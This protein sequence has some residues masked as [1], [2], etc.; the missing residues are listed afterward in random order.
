MRQR[1]V[2]AFGFDLAEIAEH[3]RLA[4]EGYEEGQISLDEYFDAGNARHPSHQLCL[5]ADSF[6]GT[7]AL[8]R[9]VINKL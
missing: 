8:P 9:F 3:S 7:G 1:V 2:D 6:S 5:H 4:F